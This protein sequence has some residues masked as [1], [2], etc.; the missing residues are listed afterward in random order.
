MSSVNKRNL[1]PRK[2]TIIIPGISSI[3]TPNRLLKAVSPILFERTFEFTNWYENGHLYK[4][5]TFPVEVVSTLRGTE[6][7]IFFRVCPCGSVYKGI[8]TSQ[9]ESL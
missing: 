6:M 9:S 3:L 8:Y 7:I 4:L 1:K 5:V 2:N